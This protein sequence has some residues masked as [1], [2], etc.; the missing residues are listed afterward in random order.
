MMTRADH[1]N[2]QATGRIRRGHQGYKRGEEPRQ[3]RYVIPRL[4]C[5]GKI[6]MATPTSICLPICPTHAP[7]WQVVLVTRCPHRSRLEPSSCEMMF[8]FSCSFFYVIIIS[9]SFGYAPRRPYLNDAALIT[10]DSRSFLSQRGQFST[11]QQIQPVHLFS[12]LRHF[13][14]THKQV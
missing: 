2:G 13:Y 14:D 3:I 4:T 6:A 1:Q 8:S 10:C 7:K 12:F 11:R 9:L 5:Q